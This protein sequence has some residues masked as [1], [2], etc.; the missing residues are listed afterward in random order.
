MRA[1]RLAL[2]AIACL[3][4]SATIGPSH[5]QTADWFNLSV[6]NASGVKGVS[7]ALTSKGDING[8][9][10]HVIGWFNVPDSGCVDLGGYWR[11][12]IWVYAL[13]TATGDFWGGDATT[14]CINP[15]D[16]FERTVT[17]SYECA[18]GEVAVGFFEVV[19]PANLGLFILTLN[20]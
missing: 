9:S 19:V 18:A 4:G 3:L 11:D 15:T 1:L 6:C 2:V 14:Q 5:A 8:Q 20:Q 7:I 12:R 17:A 13:A 16:R 10:L